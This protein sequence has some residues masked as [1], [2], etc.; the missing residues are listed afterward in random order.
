MAIIEETISQILE[1]KVKPKKGKFVYHD[2]PKN[3]RLTLQAITKKT[4]EV[5][6]KITGFSKGTGHIASHIEYI[7][8]EG[9]EV[10]EN[11]KGELFKGRENLESA[12]SDWIKD[13]E[14]FPKEKSSK[15]SRDVMHLMLSMPAGTD[16]EKVRDAARNFAKKAFSENHE[17]LF[18]LHTDQPHPHVHLA[19]KMLGFNNKKLD[20]KK[21][22]IQAWREGFAEE[23][24][25]LGV[26]ALATRRQARGVVKKATKGAVW[27]INNNKQPNRNK[28]TANVTR[29]QIKEAATELALEAK[30]ERVPDKPW[31]KAIERRQNEVRQLYKKLSDELDKTGQK[32]DK[33]LA[34]DVRKFLAGMP[35]EILTQNDEIKRR[36]TQEAVQA[37]RTATVDKAPER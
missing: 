14:S 12:Y 18:A 24:R 34:Q 19:V 36:I 8:R 16:P 25:T 30:G 5:M 29:S 22:D 23:L 27:Q 13:I 28:R 7:A 20:P 9:E 10:L 35:K 26:A 4:P 32:E 17:Y 1:G 33:K 31:N 3:A 2:K 15:T 37:K 21:N 11:D 6:A